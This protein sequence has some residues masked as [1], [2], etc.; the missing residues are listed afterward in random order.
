MAT[1]ARAIGRPNEVPEPLQ[2]AA[3]RLR[4]RLLEG[5][6]VT[7]R[8][9]QLGGVS[10]AILEGGDGPPVVLLH[11]SGEFAA[12]WMRRYPGPG[13]DPPRDRARSARP[14]RIGRGQRLRWTPSGQS[15]GSASSIERTCPTPPRGGRP[16]ARRRHRSPLRRRARRTYQPPGAR[17]L[18][19][20]GS[21]RAGA[22]LRARLA[23]TSWSSRPRR[24]RDDLFAQCFRESSMGCAKNM[25]ERWP[26]DRGLRPRPC[27]A[28]RACRP[29]SAASWPHVGM[30]AIPAGGPG[31]DRRAHY[32]DLGPARPP[33]PPAGRRGRERPP[34]LAPAR[35]RR[36]R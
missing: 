24:T 25:G 20:P 32:V 15:P 1:Q 31:A 21:I 35:Y 11:S 28:H 18:L 23:P 14:R 2:P 19:R 34:R 16:R 33:G 27:P 3:D 9:L 10:T 17:G 12:L 13:D 30:P 29:R 5:L 22:E 26:L 8:M 7:E 4:E 36:R 6:P